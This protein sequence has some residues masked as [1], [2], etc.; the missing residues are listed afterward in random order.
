MKTTPLLVVHVLPG[1]HAHAIAHALAA[2]SQGDG[3]QSAPV[4]VESA[5]QHIAE[6]P[7]AA[8]C[9]V[10]QDPIPALC[11]AMSAKADPAVF[12]QDWRSCAEQALALHRRNRQR[13]VIYESGHLQ[14]FAAAGLARLNIDADSRKLGEIADRAPPPAPLNSLLARA[15]LA[16]DT[17]AQAA[18]EELSASA[19]VLSNEDNLPPPNMALTAYATLQS[20][21]E[22]LGRQLDEKTA[23]IDLLVAQQAELTS[24]LQTLEKTLAQNTEAFAREKADFQTQLEEK[25]AR[26]SLLLEQ[27]A[28]M[29]ADLNLLEKELEAAKSAQN[30]L[31]IRLNAEKHAKDHV[32]RERDQKVAELKA[33]ME[34]HDQTATALVQRDAE[35]AAAHA[36][37]DRIMNSRSMRLTRSLR[38]LSSLLRGRG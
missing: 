16:E 38:S 6:N 18:Y 26:N 23:R 19:Q 1:D 3:A 15:I 21:T 5:G 37:I 28:A 17:A 30:E 11:A 31:T 32:T 12:L 4:S 2:A 9:I 29:V 33:T 14:R 13:S 36:E 25:T 7:E 27:Q 34:T 35:L 24:N 22:D 20:Q 8:L 10:Y